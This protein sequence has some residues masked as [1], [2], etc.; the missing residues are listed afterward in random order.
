MKK[1]T[2][3]F[4]LMLAIT[5]MSFSCEKDD[6]TPDNPSTGLITLNELNGLWNFQLLQYPGLTPDVT[7]TTT[8]AQLN[9]NPITNNMRWINLSLKIYTQ[10]SLTWCDLIDGL[11]G[12]DND[13]KGNGLILNTT[14]NVITIDNGLTFEI[15][16]YD[17]IN[18]VL[19]LKLIAPVKTN[20]NVLDGAT[21][22]LK[23]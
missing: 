15:K 23:K 19:L 12:P 13:T 18:K 20:D 2:Y 16:S 4:S 1:L 9:L 5:L 14:T 10:Y 17:K 6:T 22:T 3:L 21:Y 8:Q 7:P 11:D